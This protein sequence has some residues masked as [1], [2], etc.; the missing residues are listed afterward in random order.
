LYQNKE[1]IEGKLTLGSSM[2]LVGRVRL[3]ATTPFLPAFEAVHGS[4]KASPAPK[5]DGR[6]WWML[7][8]LG[9]SF[10]LQELTEIMSSGSAKVSIFAEPNLGQ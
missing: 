3:A 10:N 8:V 7:L 5:H 4:S 9:V 6:R 2:S 1:G